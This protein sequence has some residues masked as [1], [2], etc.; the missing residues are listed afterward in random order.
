VRR[1]DRVAPVDEKDGHERGVADVPHGAERDPDLPL[2]PSWAA[3]SYC[4]FS[5]R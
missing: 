2:D 3:S 1:D 4:W 5:G